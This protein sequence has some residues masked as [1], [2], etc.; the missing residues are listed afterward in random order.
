M[1]LAKSVEQIKELKGIGGSLLGRDDLDRKTLVEVD[2]DVERKVRSL[3]RAHS[4]CPTSPLL[5]AKGMFSVVSKTR[6][7]LPHVFRW[8][9]VRVLEHAGLHSSVM[10]K[11]GRE[12]CFSKYLVGAVSQVIIHRVLL[13]RQ[14]S[15]FLSVGCYMDLRASRALK[16]LGCLEE[17]GTF[18]RKEQK[19]RERKGHS[20]S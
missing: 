18:R 9:D 5:A 17:V 7:N 12:C 14:Q 11:G 16:S 3:E 4:A 10:K 13:F 1:L 2:G 20:K 19:K 6:N 15:C 8:S